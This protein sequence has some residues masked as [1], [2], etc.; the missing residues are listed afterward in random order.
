[1]AVS[2][3][4][5][6]LAASDGRYAEVSTGRVGHL[7]LGFDTSEMVE[8]GGAASSAPAQNT[9]G[10][11]TFS[12][13]GK[14]LAAGDLSG[15]VTLLDGGLKRR[16]G[17]M[18]GLVTSD[19]Q[20]AAAAVVALAFSRT[21]GTLAVGGDDGTVRLWDV[22]ANQPLGTAL[23]TP[24]DPVQALSFAPGNDTL[25]VAS[26]YVPS[27]TYKVSPKAVAATVCTRA[28][29]GP[30]AREW[31]QMIPEVPYRRLC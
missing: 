13:D 30:S 19:R 24:S 27:Q 1:M 29:G 11:L 18:S 6:M 9:I 17:I 10:T 5:H 4:G 14:Y 31:H 16:L 20:D 2:P 12:P 23:P 22:A 26:D 25:Y 28:D 7:P 3:D 15:R 21:G 8:L